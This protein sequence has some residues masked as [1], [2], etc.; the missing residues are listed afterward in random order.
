M[1]KIS[2][3]FSMVMLRG[4]RLPISAMRDTFPAGSHQF[5]PFHFPF[6]FLYGYS[7]CIRSL[8][9]SFVILDLIDNGTQLGLSSLKPRN[10]A[11]LLMGP[12]TFKYSRRGLGVG[13]RCRLAHFRRIR[14][15]CCLSSSRNIFNGQLL[16]L[17]H[18]FATAVFLLHQSETWVHMDRWLQSRHF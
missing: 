2:T 17:L 3:A 1:V 10:S 9:R 6:E 12:F 13:E 8:H 16:L 18:S 7:A 14:L 11:T 15:F 5:S 4:W